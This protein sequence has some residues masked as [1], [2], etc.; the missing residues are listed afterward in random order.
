MDFMRNVGKDMDTILT[1]MEKLIP[2]VVIEFTTDEDEIENV[3]RLVE[4]VMTISSYDEL[5]LTVLRKIANIDV[6]L[7]EMKNK[8][9]K[10]GNQEIQRLLEMKNRYGIFVSVSRHRFKDLLKRLQVQCDIKMWRIV[11]EKIGLQ[12][13]DE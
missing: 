9:I 12:R 7:Y 6:K 5:V 11:F 10:K 2:D 8:R 13:C 1:Q 4:Y 3:S